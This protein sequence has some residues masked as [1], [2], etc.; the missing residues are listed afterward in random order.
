MSVDLQRCS[1][2]CVPH[3]GLQHGYGFALG[4]L[5]CQAMSKSVQSNVLSGNAKLSENGLQPGANYVV[6]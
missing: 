4:Q 3:L 6:S 5:C 2:I 1:D